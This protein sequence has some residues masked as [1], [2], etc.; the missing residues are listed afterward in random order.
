MPVVDIPNTGKHK[1]MR[2]VGIPA[3]PIEIGNGGILHLL[4]VI[5]A[6]YHLRL[7]GPA[8]DD[9]RERIGRLNR[10]AA[11]KPLGELY[12]SAVVDRIGA[13]VENADAPES[14]IGPRRSK[15][16]GIT[17]VCHGLASQSTLCSHGWEQIDV[18]SPG[19]MFTPHAKIADRDAVVLAELELGVQAPLMRERLNV[20]FRED[21]NVG[22]AV[23]R[24][25]SRE[26]VRIDRNSTRRQS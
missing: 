19:E 26:Y 22:S 16:S 7:I 3:A 15:G 24:R 11:R 4:R 13:A 20:D 21:I 9:L 6:H 2:Y 17:Q 8:V 23:Q 1:T 5:G 12:E 14:C 25:R 18:V 10:K